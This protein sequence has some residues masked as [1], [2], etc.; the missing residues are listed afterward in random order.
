MKL[1]PQT[2]TPT[3][4]H[5][6]E[7]SYF[8]EV[9]FNITDITK[10]WKLL[11]SLIRGHNTFLRIVDNHIRVWVKGDSKDVNGGIVIFLLEKFTADSREK[12]MVHIDR[13]NIFLLGHNKE[14]Y[15]NKLVNIKK[16]MYP[17]YQVE[18][19]ISIT[20]IQSRVMVRVR[21]SAPSSSRR[22]EATITVQRRTVNYVALSSYNTT[23]V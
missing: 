20:Y 13:H 1:S 6:F 22:A 9:P 5:Y 3:L 8:S 10:E 23:M 12:V 2:K 19:D 16:T 4:T 17:L 18:V 7:T 15:V 11:Y 21:I 14:N